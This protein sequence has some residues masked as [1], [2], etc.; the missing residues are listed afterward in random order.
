M[1]IKYE[2]VDN[3]LEVC[4]F[5]ENLPLGCRVISVSQ[6]CGDYTIFYQ[7]PERGNL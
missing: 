1:K 6:G 5:I 7:Q 3:E 2:I 4:S